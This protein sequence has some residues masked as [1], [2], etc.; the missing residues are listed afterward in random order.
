MTEKLS[1]PKVAVSLTV[2]ALAI[3]GMFVWYSGEL[4][5]GSFPAVNLTQEQRNLLALVT[6]VNARGEEWSIPTGDYAFTVSSNPKLYP[7][8]LSGDID[9]L[10][11]K[12]GDTQRMK[13]VVVDVAPPK[14]VWAEIEH[15]AGQ[16]TV[17]L[18]L[19]DTKALAREEWEKKPYLVDE[20]GRLILNDAPNSFSV[21][22]IVEKLVS[23]AEAEGEAEYTYEGSWVVHDTHTKTYR[24]TFVAESQTGRRNQMVMAWSD[25]CSFSPTGGLVTSCSYSSGI[26]G[27]DGDMN[28]GGQ[29]ITLSGSAVLS[30]SPGRSIT[31][32]NTAGT[33]ITLS[34]GT[35]E[36]RQLCVT[37]V[38]GDGYTPSVGRVLG[39]ITAG[40]C[41][42]GT[43]TLASVAGGQT[44]IT[45]NLDCF[46]GN[47]N[48]H[49]GQTQYFETDRGDG[50]FDYDCDNLAPSYANSDKAGLDEFS[51]LRLPGTT[52]YAGP[53]AAQCEGFPVDDTVSGPAAECGEDW[54]T[55]DGYC[56]TLPTFKESPSWF[57]RVLE[58]L[59]GRTAEADIAGVGFYS[60]NSCKTCIGV[61]TAVCR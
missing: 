39:G 7:R 54:W 6:Y 49:P 2:F 24:T 53:P 19:T 51:A 8:F 38:D 21:Q 58:S 5:T 9:P 45:A 36:N 35:I 59:F 15:D 34:G 1:K 46:D 27:F 40:E 44:N 4:P 23:R 32:L 47:A 13:I 29:T 55:P 48:A 22:S 10:D 43:R 11:V 52:L 17:E 60:D 28:I 57:A 26:D 3:G 50:S 61:I 31:G 41:P 37:D 16:D 30:L 33:Q 12:V 25:P 20:S 56:S 18:T 42:A 14:R